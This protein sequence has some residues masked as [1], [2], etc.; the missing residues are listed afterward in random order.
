MT[1]SRGKL[2]RE[3]GAQAAAPQQAQDYSL[4][5]VR[6]GTLSADAYI[7]RAQLQHKAMQRETDELQSACKVLFQA[8][9]TT[10]RRTRRLV[11]ENLAMVGFCARDEALQGI[12]ER[13]HGNA[14]AA[15]P[16]LRPLMDQLMEGMPQI[17]QMIGEDGLRRMLGADEEDKQEEAPPQAPSQADVPVPV[18]ASAKGM[19]EGTGEARGVTEDCV[20]PR[21]RRPGRHPRVPA[22]RAATWRARP[23]AVDPP[24]DGGLSARI[25]GKGRQG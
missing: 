2:I 24:Q 13:Y 8:L 19:P 6:R 15:A 11:D 23:P 5:A 22:P 16:A 20:P 12:A 4:D 18:W 9:Q 3:Q 10:Q 14:E 1:R 17:A 25:H 21:L 7:A